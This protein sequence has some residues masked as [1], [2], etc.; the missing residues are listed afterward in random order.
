MFYTPVARACAAVAP[1]IRMTCN[2]ERGDATLIV[3]YNLQLTP[4]KVAL[5]TSAF[6]ITGAR[7]EK[8][9]EAVA[10]LPLSHPHRNGRQ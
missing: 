10:E 5:S 6:S 7:I 3:P 2:E 9:Q 1:L 8:M 4:G